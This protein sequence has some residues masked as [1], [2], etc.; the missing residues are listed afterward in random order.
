MKTFAPSNSCSMRVSEQ[1]YS[2]PQHT[3]STHIKSSQLV[4]TGSLQLV[5]NLQEMIWIN[6]E[7]KIIIWQGNVLEYLPLHNLSHSLSLIFFRIRHWNISPKGVNL[8]D[9]NDTSNALVLI[10]LIIEINTSLTY[11]QFYEHFTLIIHDFW[12]NSA[13]WNKCTDTKKK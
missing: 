3:T 10:K 7:P 6:K 12:E 2:M 4:C 11:L 8:S 9:C 13:N 1:V 5:F